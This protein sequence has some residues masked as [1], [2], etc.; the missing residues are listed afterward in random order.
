MNLTYLVLA[1]A[2]SRGTNRSAAVS[3]SSSPRTRFY[4]LGC[5][6]YSSRV[7]KPSMFG[8]GLGPSIPLFYRLYA[9]RCIEF[10]DIYAWEAKPH[11]PKQ[12]YAQVPA[13]MAEKIRFYNLPVESETNQSASPASHPL[14]LLELARPSDFVVV[15]VDIDGAGEFGAKAPELEIVEAI[16]ARP[17][18]SR[19]V[20]ELF[21]E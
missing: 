10:D 21:F 18:L 2:C 17:E 3:G 9:D 5:T 20:D 19:L 12:W 8:T 4:D 1:N 11:D 7:N 15:K 6:T 14:R 16:A 13:T